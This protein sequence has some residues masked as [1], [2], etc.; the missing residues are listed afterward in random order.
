MNDR[1][2]NKQESPWRMDTE[3]VVFERTNGRTC[4]NRTNG[5][6]RIGRTGTDVFY[7]GIVQPR[8]MVDS[9]GG[10][11]DPPKVRSRG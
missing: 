2:T 9:A 8:A 4:S 1:Q 6:V 11:S 5:R 7:G 3:L 10:I